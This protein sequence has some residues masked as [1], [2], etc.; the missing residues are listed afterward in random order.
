MGAFLLLY[1]LMAGPQ[2]AP[3]LNAD[4]INS[5][6]AAAMGPGAEGEAVV[7]AQ[8]LLDRAHF[9]PG[10]IDGRY[11]R[12]VEKAV[13]A[14]QAARGLPVA[15]FIDG[16]TWAALNADTA[17]VLVSYTMSEQDVAGPFVP[18]PRDMMRKAKLERLGYQSPREQLGEKFHSSPQLLERLNPG[19]TLAVAG[20]RILAPNVFSPPPLGPAARLEVSKSQSAVMAYGAAGKLLGWY[21]ATLG[22]EHDP[23]PIGEWK[24]DLVKWDPVFHYNPDLFW[25]ADSG[26]E[27]ARIAPGP[28]SPVGVVWINL[29]KPHY[30]IHGTPDPGEV[31]HVTSHGCIRL[32]N[33]DAAE[34]A[35]MLRPGT[36]AFLTE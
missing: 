3:P 11:G 18:V 10:E 21:V 27:R 17:P 9:S 6:G 24:I 19:K 2:E 13:S 28:N 35:G 4:T 22:S 29:T 7:R 30:G 20:E 36:P 32:T 31:G 15:G 14:F 33:W 23:L 34:L 12:N 8:V 25:D 26:H 1:A 16:Q 5:P